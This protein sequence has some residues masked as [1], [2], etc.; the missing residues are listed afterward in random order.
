MT[1]EELELKQEVTELKIQLAKALERIEGLENG[2]TSGGIY[3][4]GVQDFYRH[5][6]LRELGKDKR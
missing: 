5:E 3:L 6:I 2:E 1:Q 4:D